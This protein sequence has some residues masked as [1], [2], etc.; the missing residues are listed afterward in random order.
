MT[1]MPSMAGA[2][3]VDTSVLVK[4]IR[5]DDEELLVEAHA[6][7]SRVDDAGV[8]VYAPTLLAYELGNILTRKSDLAPDRIAEAL[9]EVFQSRLVVA[10]PEPELLARGAR[11]ARQH[12]ITFYD[13]AFVALAEL[14]HCPLVTADRRLARRTRELDFVRHLSNARDV[15]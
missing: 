2:L 13:A 8:T 7:R 9:D 15:P 3:V 1:A 4:W 5:S 10:P 14:L 6:L 11:L 12:D